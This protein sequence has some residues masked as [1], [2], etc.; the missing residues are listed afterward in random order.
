MSTTMTAAQAVFSTYELREQIFLELPVP[1]LLCCTMVSEVWKDTIEK[2]PEVRHLLEGTAGQVKLRTVSRH[3]QRD[4]DRDAYIFKN[5]NTPYSC[6]NNP[7]TT[8]L[9][10]QVGETRCLFSW[11]AEAELKI[12]TLNQKLDWSGTGGAVH[13][14]TLDGKEDCRIG[15]CEHGKGCEK[16]WY[17]GLAKFKEKR[18]RQNRGQEGVRQRSDEKEEDTLK[19][20]R[21]G[22]IHVKVR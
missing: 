3:P 19:Y 16:L 20:E 8:Y 11:P 7:K 9:A 12:W 17:P 18:M 15:E 4:E 22:T 1:A 2:S 5:E 21:W 6:H 13:E 14:V 10:V